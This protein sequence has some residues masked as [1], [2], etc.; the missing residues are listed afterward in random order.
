[1]K[2]LGGPKQ[3]KKCVNLAT[4]PPPEPTSRLSFWMDDDSSSAQPSPSNNNEDDGPSPNVPL[5]SPLSL[6]SPLT[7]RSILSPHASP[8][9]TIKT[10][11][12]TL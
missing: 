4:A 3:V 6:L 7:A 11:S 1:M 2:L 5:A 9:T 10:R 8:L 12:P